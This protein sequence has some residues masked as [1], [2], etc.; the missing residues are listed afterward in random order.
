MGKLLKGERD[1]RTDGWKE[2]RKKKGEKSTDNRIE[3]RNVGSSG[4]CDAASD[5]SEETLGKSNA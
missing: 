3:G 5:L 2:E 4:T 1:G